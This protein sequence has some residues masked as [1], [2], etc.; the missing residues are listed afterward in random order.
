MHEIVFAS[1][2]QHKIKEIRAILGP[3]FL[4]K[5]LSAIGCTHDIPE[6]FE[7]LEENALAKARYVADNYGFDCF[8]DDTGLEVA[9]LGGM[10]GVYSARYAGP[11]KESKKNVRKLLAELQNKPCRQARFRTVIA[12]IWQGDHYFF[13]GVVTGEIT[14]RLRG[15]EGFGY[16]PVFVP[17]GHDQTFAEMAADEKNTISHRKRAVEKLTG[18]LKK[19]LTPR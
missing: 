6:P 18:F 1:N 12:L 7:T 17:E 15:N 19:Q 8:A 11:E 2:N 4:L 3:D 16:D 5:G 13:E 14:T 9:C 10:P